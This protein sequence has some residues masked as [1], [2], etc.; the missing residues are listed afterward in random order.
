MLVGNIFLLFATAATALSSPSHRRDATQLAT[1]TLVQ[2]IQNI[3]T[4]VKALTAAVDAFPGTDLT[5]FAVSGVSVFAG[6]ADIH[7]V[8]RKGYADALASPVL[9]NAESK[10]I[11][12]FTVATV[13]NSIPA[14]VDALE[15]KKDAFAA[16][17]LVP[18]AL[19][20]LK[21]LKYDHDTFSAA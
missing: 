2:D 5:T 13:G 19:A 6:V 3:D 11:V 17:G 20:G 7:V 1:D 18:V 9:D 12:D 4:G 14:G 15:A 21:L 16:A 10:E 8:N